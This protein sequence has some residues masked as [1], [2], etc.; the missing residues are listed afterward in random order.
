MT[1]EGQFEAAP[2]FRE[3]T[4]NLLRAFLINEGR[5]LHDR[6]PHIFG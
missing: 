6:D 1:R 5:D 2:S 4:Y 3:V